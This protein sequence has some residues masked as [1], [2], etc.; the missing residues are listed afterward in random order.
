MLSPFL[1]LNLI[2]LHYLPY[3]LKSSHMAF[4]L[5]LWYTKF[6]LLLALRVATP[7]DYNHFPQDLCIDYP[8]IYS[9]PPKKNYFLTILTKTVH[10]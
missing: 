1:F 7:F 10:T 3:S 4:L 6:I 5:F 2:F 9:I 8:S